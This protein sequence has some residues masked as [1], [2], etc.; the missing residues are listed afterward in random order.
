MD[1]S[2]KARAKWI[3]RPQARQG[4]AFRLVCFPQAGGNAWSFRQWAQ[5]L[6]TAIEL[7]AIQYPGH[8]DRL[9]EEPRR[10]FDVLLTEIAESL[11][12][13]LDRPY[14]LFGHSM[15][16]LLAFE[17]GRVLQTI[18]VGPPK[19]V[20][21]SGHNAPGNPMA[22]DD[23]TPAHELTDPQLLERIE[24]LDCTPPEILEDREM[25]TLL[26]RMIRADSAVC[27]SHVLRK[28]FP[29]ASPVTV[30]GGVDDPRTSEAGLNSW[31]EFSS[32]RFDV[33]WFEGNH[34]FLFAEEQRVQETIVGALVRGNG[35]VCS[36]G[37]ARR[38]TQR[39]D[40]LVQREASETEAN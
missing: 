29:L 18:D 26:L 7:L 36:D 20:F 3:V 12:P 5:R 32:G 16:A 31:R 39:K 33:R 11:A 15:G 22:S 1:Q 19:H 35:F 38:E 8:G 10:D 27:E 34:G 30:L 17:T 24:T 40:T 28:R 9:G 37:C 6:P 13:S 2:E 23:R 4:A 25:R 21:L 14:A